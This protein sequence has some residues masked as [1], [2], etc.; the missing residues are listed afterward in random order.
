MPRD[1]SPDLVFYKIDASQC[2]LQIGDRVTP[3][4]TIGRDWRS[5]QTVR[6]GRRGRVE[7]IAFTGAEHALIIAIRPTRR[8]GRK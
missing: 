3:Q 5:K 4:T 8:R 1:M 7:S 2:D 6:A